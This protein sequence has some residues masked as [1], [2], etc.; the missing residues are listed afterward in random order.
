L[1]WDIRVKLEECE[2][3]LAAFSSSL[4]RL[5]LLFYDDPLNL[6][7]NLILSAESAR[8]PTQIDDFRTTPLEAVLNPPTIASTP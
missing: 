2:R 4:A 7:F 1:D 3:L 6:V 8:P 5:C